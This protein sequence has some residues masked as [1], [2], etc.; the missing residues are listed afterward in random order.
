MTGLNIPAPLCKLSAL[1]LRALINATAHKL[2]LDKTWNARRTN[3]REAL[4][5]HIDTM[6]NEFGLVVT[7]DG[8][9][10]KA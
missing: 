7:D 8:T 6:C 10:A 1:S 5:S 2:S 4:L 3:D 9:L